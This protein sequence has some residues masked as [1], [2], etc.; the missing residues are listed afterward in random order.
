M[1]SITGDIDNISIFMLLIPMVDSILNDILQ[2]VDQTDLSVATGLY[3]KTRDDDSL[4][5]YSTLR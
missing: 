5:S 4:P 2:Y 1:V 3:M